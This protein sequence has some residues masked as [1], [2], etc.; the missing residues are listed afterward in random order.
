M[1][2]SSL[3]LGWYLRIFKT[4]HIFKI[5][6]TE[7]E[8]RYVAIPIPNARRHKTKAVCP[9]NYVSCLPH[10]PAAWADKTNHF[11]W[12][13]YANKKNFKKKN[14]KKQQS[15]KTRIPRHSK[16]KQ[17]AAAAHNK[18]MFKNVEPKNLVKLNLT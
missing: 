14:G 5:S 4:F 8:I 3:L 15:Q 7:I 18:K 6:T 11:R 9:N 1:I 17:S 16:N 10:P 2:S 13:P 12:L